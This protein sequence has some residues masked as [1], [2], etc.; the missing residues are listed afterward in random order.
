M[1]TEQLETST[2]TGQKPSTWPKAEPPAVRGVPIWEHRIVR[3]L[4]V[5]LLIA[6]PMAALWFVWQ[7]TASDNGSA[8][9]AAVPQVAA[10][11]VDLSYDPSPAIT[12]PPAAPVNQ[13]AEHGSNLDIPRDGTGAA[14]TEERDT[15]LL[16]SK[17]HIG[18]QWEDCIHACYVTANRGQPV[19]RYGRT[20]ELQIQQTENNREKCRLATE[21]HCDSTAPS[22]NAGEYDEICKQRFPSYSPEAL[23]ERV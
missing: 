23:Q 15:Y 12:V 21:Q 7:R 1:A 22:E 10:Q 2:E 6:M 11:Q 17:H 3:A 14:C 16:N 4:L 13:Q 9:E 5:A 19:S 20:T 18:R 8:S